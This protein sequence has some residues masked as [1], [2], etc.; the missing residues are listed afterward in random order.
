MLK[1]FGAL[2][3]G[4]LIFAGC[5]S[6]P[7][8]VTSTS[9]IYTFIGDQPV[10]DVLSFQLLITAMTLQ[11]AP[12]TP[13]FAVLPTSAAIKVDF[14]ALQD[15]S[16][17]MNLNTVPPGTYNQIKLSIAAP[18][19]VVYNP[20][21]NPPTQTITPSLST[22]SPVFPIN[23]PLVVTAG[24]AGAVRVD[25]NLGQSVQLGSDG[26]IS[27]SMTPVFSATSLSASATQGSGALDDVY[28]FVTTVNN[29]V[30]NS[31]TKFTGSFVLQ[32]LLNGSG[33]QLTVQLNSSSQLLGVSALNQLTT[34]TFV[35]VN[36][37]VDSGGN[38]VANTANAE[39]REITESNQVAFL[40]I[41]ESVTRDSNG[42]VTQFNFFN[43]DE[44]PNTGFT[45]T[46]DSTVVVTPSAQTTYG[47]SFPAGNF[48][49]LPF[50]QTAITRG[51]QLIVH[52]TFTPPP[53]NLPSGTTPPPVQ[54]AANLI[55]NQL[56]VHEGNFSSLLATGSDN[57]T[58]AFLLV[59]CATIFNNA[60][61]YVFTTAS[62][63]FV[64]V[65]GLSGLTP[66]PS[67][68]VKGLFFYSLKATTIDNVQVPPGSWVLLASQVHQLT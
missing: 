38:F 5:S 42:N 50:D 52:G 23:P 3:L 30:P 7:P 48:A 26:Q 47:V 2:T 36:G 63:Q 59:P 12:G 64:N 15:F 14:A 40:G 33:P 24:N 25:F 56:Q 68:L 41:V 35:E 29:T 58:G 21:D 11:G 37:Y 17:V 28:G 46:L 57:L 4:V 6:A 55:I 62:T 1:R 27:S 54:V 19:L 43:R 13:G 9:S 45:V 66:V 60:P 18:Q 65:D 32:L 22:E 16:T 10:C 44:Q 31:S 8:K 49:S 34:G 20:A 51:Q 53:S 39:Y 61:I 67:L